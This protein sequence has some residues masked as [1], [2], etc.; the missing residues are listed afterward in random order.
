MKSFC[1]EICLWQVAVWCDMHICVEQA[2]QNIREHRKLTK[3]PY[4]AE[5]AI[6][7]E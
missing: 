4:N 7:T 6:L 2:C 5:I 1:D 3:H